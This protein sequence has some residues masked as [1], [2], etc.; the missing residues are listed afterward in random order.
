MTQGTNI[1]A[2]IQ[3][4]ANVVYDYDENGNTIS[5]NNR[6][7]VY[8]LSNR[9]ITVQEVSVTIAQYVYNALNQRIKKILPAETRIFHYDLQGHL[10]AETNASGS[11]ACQSI[12]IL[13]ISR[14]R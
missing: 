8:D 12:F 1:L 14:W 4:E 5:A 9:L 10:I 2:D 11:D 7:F 3:G 13:A 6:T